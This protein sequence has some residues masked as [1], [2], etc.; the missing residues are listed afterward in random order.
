MREIKF[1]AWDGEGDGMFLQ[2]EQSDEFM[3][4]FADDGLT[5]AVMEQTFEMGSGVAVE[6]WGYRNVDAV[7]MQFTGLQDKNGVDIYEG[8]IVKDRWRRTIVYYDH[9]GFSPFEYDGGGEMEADE[10]EVIGNTHEHNELLKG[11]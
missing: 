7:F 11:E 9:S 1:R 5:L 4:G 8:D 2:E 10:C 6:N 3:F